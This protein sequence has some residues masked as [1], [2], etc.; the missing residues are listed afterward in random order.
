MK[1]KLLKNIHGARNALSLHC[2]AGVTTVNKVG[3]LPGYSTV[4]FYEHDIANILSLN[5]VNK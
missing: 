2:F 4:W 5:K 3:D 1:K